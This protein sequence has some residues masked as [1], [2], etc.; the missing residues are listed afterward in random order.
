[1]LIAFFL[2]GLALGAGLLFWHNRTMTHARRRVPKQWPLTVRT[3]VNSDE[4]RVWAWLDKAMF[5]QQ[6]LVKLPVTRFTA[7]TNRQEAG[8]WF[9]LLNAVYCTFTVCTEEGRV[10]AC[11]DVTGPLRSKSNQMLKHTLLSQCGIRYCVLDSTKLPHPTQLRVE[12]LGEEAATR[13][14]QAA[15][16]ARFK[17]VKYNLQAALDKQRNNKRRSFGTPA[18]VNAD[19]SKSQESRQTSGWEQ[20]SFITP[21]DSRIAELR[22]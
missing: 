5:D 8:H 13:T 9:E 6:I 11:V 4:K 17:D 3:L 16:D 2:A 14:E 12:F 1:M 10:I 15:L 20:N 18:S 19:F 7:P 22:P 21:L